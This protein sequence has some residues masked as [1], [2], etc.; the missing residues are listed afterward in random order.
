MPH[1]RCG[2]VYFAL[3]ALLLGKSIADIPIGLPCDLAS[4]EAHLLVCV[5]SARRPS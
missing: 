4:L 3:F 2:H 1:A 5:R